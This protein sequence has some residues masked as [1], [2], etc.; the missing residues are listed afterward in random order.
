MVPAELTKRTD[1]SSAWGVRKQRF[2]GPVSSAVS[3]ETRVASIVV[4]SV[5]D[6][7]SVSM[8]VVGRSPSGKGLCWW[9]WAVW[10]ATVGFE[11]YFSSK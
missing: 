8:G 9:E 10:T 3:G 7:V 11:T 1:I 6:F 2:T 4:W 5:V